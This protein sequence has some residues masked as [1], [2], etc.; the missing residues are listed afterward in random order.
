MKCDDCPNL[1]DGVC[2][3]VGPHAPTDDANWQRI[4][5]HIELMKKQRQNADKEKP[6]TA[7]N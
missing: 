2:C 5:A 4:E 3:H 1:T 7:A 6:Q